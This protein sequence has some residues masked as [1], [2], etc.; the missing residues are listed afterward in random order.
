[1]TAT[2]QGMDSFS[3]E[4]LKEKYRLEREKRLRPTAPTSSSST[5][6]ARAWVGTAREGIRYS[7]A[8]SA[9]H[10]IAAMHSISTRAPYAS[11]FVPRALRAG[12]CPG[13]KVT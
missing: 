6:R 3:P 13:K 8:G 1:M 10:S 12:F 5:P 7:L 4:A 9:H 11:P 2:K